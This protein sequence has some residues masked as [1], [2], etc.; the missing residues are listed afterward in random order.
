MFDELINRTAKIDEQDFRLEILNALMRTP[1]RQVAP[2]L[3][4]FR[5]VHGRDPLFFGRLAAWYFDN[6]SVL[7]IKQ[8]FVAFMA[9]SKFS[10]EYRDA[11]IALLQKLPPYQVERVLKMVKGHEESGIWIEGV[12][13]SVPRSFRTAVEEYLH[14]R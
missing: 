3:P 13:P 1:H 14:D 2:Y 4:L 8:L 11:G 7:D 9:T 10:D 6:G 12:S 5:Y